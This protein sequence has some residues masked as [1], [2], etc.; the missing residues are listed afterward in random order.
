VAA[1]RRVHTLPSF[2]SNS[3]TG[4]SRTDATKQYEGGLYRD[5]LGYHTKSTMGD[6]WGRVWRWD[7]VGGASTSAAHVNCPT[8][9]EN[10]ALCIPCSP[11]YDLWECVASQHESLPRH[12][13]RER[14]KLTHRI[15]GKTCFRI[16][17]V[18]LNRL[19]TFEG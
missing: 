2:A 13:T 10:I 18:H 6:G 7:T 15:A 14:R 11:R 19:H 17:R 4:H 5:A 9:Q 12:Q 1:V 8:N 16:A 3:F